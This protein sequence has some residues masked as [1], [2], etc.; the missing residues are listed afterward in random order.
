MDEITELNRRLDEHSSMLLNDSRE[1]AKIARESVDT[2]NT[3]D[4]ARAK[5]MLS[6]KI[7]CTGQGWTVDMQKAEA[8]LRCEREMVDA[9]IAESHLDS[10]KMRLKS[11]AD[12]LSAVQTKARLL[13]TESDLNGYQR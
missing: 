11:V 12:S 13:K 7:E 4:L 1:Y 10:L 2:R 3:L 6:V 8:L 9:R 5:A